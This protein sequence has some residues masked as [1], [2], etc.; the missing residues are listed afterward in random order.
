MNSES[1][2]ERSE[3]RT[4]IKTVQQLLRRYDKDHRVVLLSLGGET[5]IT[6]DADAALEEV[7]RLTPHVAAL[8]DSERDRADDPL[9][10]A[11]AAFVEAC[12][13]AEVPC[14]VL[15]YRAIEHYFPDD[16]VK[17]VKGPKYRAL[18]PYED[19]RAVTPMWAREEN[20]RIARELTREYLDT[21]DLGQFLA[22]L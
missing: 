8:I 1:T 14:H 5:L 7:K 16:A 10:P 20:W 9:A 4:E 21:T 15:K 22:T 3:S 13:R 2:K 6:A 11:R 17:R 12:Q 19:R 18:G